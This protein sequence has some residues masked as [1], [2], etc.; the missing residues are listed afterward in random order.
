MKFL[1]ELYLFEILHGR[2]SALEINGAWFETGL[3]ELRAE[4][5][6]YLTTPSH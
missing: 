5:T 4:E 3:S 1:Q 6:S 2:K